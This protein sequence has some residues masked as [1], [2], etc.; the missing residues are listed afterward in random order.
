MAKNCDHLNIIKLCHSKAKLTDKNL[1][2]IAL[3]A[4]KYNQIE[5]INFTLKEI[6]EKYLF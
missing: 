6:S 2:D 1:E 4:A 5:T 3:D